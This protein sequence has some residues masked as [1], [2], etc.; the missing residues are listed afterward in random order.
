MTRR[1]PVSTPVYN[2]QYNAENQ[3]TAVSGSAS[4]RFVY[5]G[6]SNCV[7]GTAGGVTTIYIGNSFEWVATPSTYT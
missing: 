1:D 7:M 3:M 6:D 5:D 4:A 2:F